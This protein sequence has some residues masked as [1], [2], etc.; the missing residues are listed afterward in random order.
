M[1]SNL[2]DNQHAAEIRS[3]IAQLHKHRDRASLYE[4]ILDALPPMLVVS[5][6]R[7]ALSLSHSKLRAASKSQRH[8]PPL[9][10]SNRNTAIDIRCHELVLPSWRGAGRSNVCDFGL[11]E[12][13][14]N[15]QKVPTAASGRLQ[16]AQHPLHHHVMS[17]E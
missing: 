17:C 15:A 13:K 7:R 5:A 9:W 1:A 3:D 2:K 6:R 4:M 12:F 14:R 11:R 10:H 16:R 8:S